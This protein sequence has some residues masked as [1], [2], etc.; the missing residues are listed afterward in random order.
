MKRVSPTLAERSRASSPRHLF[1]PSLP[2]RL[3]PPVAVFSPSKQG[4]SGISCKQARD[5]PGTR[6]ADVCLQS[7]LGRSQMIERY[8]RWFRLESNTRRPSTKTN[9]QRPLCASLVIERDGNALE[10]QLSYVRGII[11]PNN[12]G[13]F[14]ARPH[15]HHTHGRRC[16]VSP[17]QPQSAILSAL[18]KQPE[19]RR[20][21]EYSGRAGPFQ[22]AGA[23]EALHSL[24]HAGFLQMKWQKRYK[25]Y[26]NCTK[27]NISF[28]D[29][30]VGDPA[31][32]LLTRNSSLRPWDTF[33]GAD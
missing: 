9:V 26:R 32:L 21:S 24:D 12:R 25:R 5:N 23:I 3:V 6:L 27:S 28:R 13:Q 7:A 2:R 4:A 18:P 20:G 19:S 22:S 16:G 30:A 33:N 31:H 29:S 14:T 8:Q 17:D 10:D 11:K 15:P 1:L